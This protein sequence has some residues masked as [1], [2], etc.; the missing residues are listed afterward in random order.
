MACRGHRL[1]N[2]K[3]GDMPAA[4]FDPEVLLEDYRRA[5]PHLTIQPE[6]MPK[7]DIES[8]NVLEALKK[9]IREAKKPESAFEFATALR[10][11]ADK[12]EATDRGHV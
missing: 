6:L 11:L 9:L 7:L 3:L 1:P 4:Y 2:A 10:D 5:Y 12:L 8:E